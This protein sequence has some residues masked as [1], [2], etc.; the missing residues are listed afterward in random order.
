MV[1]QVMQACLQHDMYL[2]AAASQ[3]QWRVCF[4]KQQLKQLGSSRSNE[5]LTGYRCFVTQCKFLQLC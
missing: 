4:Y 5:C 3:F 2:K 1:P